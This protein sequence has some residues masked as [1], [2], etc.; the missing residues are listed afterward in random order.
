[1]V[2]KRLAWQMQQWLPPL[3]GYGQGTFRCRFGMQVGDGAGDG[4]GNENRSGGG[5]GDGM[6]GWTDGKTDGEDGG[7]MG[8]RVWLGVVAADGQITWL[9]MGVVLRLILRP[10]LVPC[11]PVCPSP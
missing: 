9:Q 10:C 5:D 4:H 8:I 11:S 3:V 6:R 1:M 7:G 2:A